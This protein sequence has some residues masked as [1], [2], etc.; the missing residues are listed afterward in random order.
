M[1]ERLR[2]P[3][4]YYGGKGQTLA[5]LATIVPDGGKPYCEPF[6]GAASLFFSRNPAPVEV[7]NDLNGDVVNF[8]RVMQ[9]R[10]T[11]EELRHRIN[12]TPY[13][14]DEFARA[15]AVEQHD[16][17][18]TRAWAFFVRQNM[19]FAGKSKT[20]GDFGRVF[21][22]CSGMSGVTNRWIMRQSMLD[23][24]RMRILHAQID[25]RCAID[26]IRYWD[27]DD[28][29]FYCDPPYIHSTRSSSDDYSVEQDDDFHHRLVS[30]LLEC[31]GAV[32][33]SCYDHPAYQ[34]LSDAGWVRHDFSTSA[35]SAGRVRGS[36]LKGAGS[37]KARVPRTETV[38][39]NPKAVERN[40]GLFRKENHG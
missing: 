1:A 15:L 19:G 35:H 4:Q 17:P 13:A 32:V 5:K 11:Y 23:A 21:T 16:D 34:P 20:V 28:A 24:F 26:V 30:A 2:A 37:A 7:L 22:T 33:L 10:N 36:G 12:W 29:V 6:C 25:N 39:V 38:W 18:I 3:F 8:F 31:K 9:D 40:N 27:N 14:R